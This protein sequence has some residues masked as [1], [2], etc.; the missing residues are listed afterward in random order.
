M[1]SLPLPSND[2]TVRLSVRLLPV[3]SA[4]TEALLLSRRYD[5]APELESKLQV[6]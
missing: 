1:V 2:W 5:Q 4:S 6:P 3:D